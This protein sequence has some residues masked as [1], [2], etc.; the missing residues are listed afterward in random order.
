MPRNY[1]L[2]SIFSLFDFWNFR[3]MQANEAVDAKKGGASTINNT[4]IP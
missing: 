2:L 3:K 1:L 4:Y